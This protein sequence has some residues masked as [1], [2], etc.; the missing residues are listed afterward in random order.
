MWFQP[1]LLS[2]RKTIRSFGYAW[3][4]IWLVVRYENNTRVHL[5]ASL[6]AVMLGIFLNLNYLEWAV[7]LMQIGLM[8]A[9]ETFNTALEKLV[10]LVS[11]EYNPLAGKV[12]D[13]AA[14]AVLFVSLMTVGVGTI[15]FGH[16][17]YQLFATGSGG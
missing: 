1:I 10:D 7:I 2:I 16:R 5:M 4:G 11:P 13:I 6:G 8:W 15:I 14:G 12:K 9:A 17:I 3:H